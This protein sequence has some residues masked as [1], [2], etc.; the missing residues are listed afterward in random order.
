[1][2]EQLESGI[3][4]IDGRGPAYAQGLGEFRRN[5]SL[6]RAL[7][8]DGAAP[9]TWLSLSVFAVLGGGLALR[10]RRR[11]EEP[12]W[13]WGALVAGLLAAPVS[14]A[15]SLTWALPLLLMSRPAVRPRREVWAVTFALGFLGLA[16]PAG[17]ILTGLAAVVTAGLGP[18]S[19]AE[20]GG[21]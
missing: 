4:R 15:M 5:A 11:P 7:T 17:W 9:P 6:T 14:W 8:P 2:A 18:G 3:A 13:F 16:T 21:P 20:R 19:R 10:G 1:V 12:G